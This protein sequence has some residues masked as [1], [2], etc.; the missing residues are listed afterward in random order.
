MG[1]SDEAPKVACEAP[2]SLREQIALRPNVEGQSRRLL[3]QLAFEGTPA[4][5]QVFS[6]FD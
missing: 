5:P 1:N 2:H 6:Q 4:T 3:S